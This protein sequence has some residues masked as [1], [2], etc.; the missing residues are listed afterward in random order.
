[1][2]TSAWAQFHWP[3]LGVMAVFACL[4]VYNTHS[5][6]DPSLLSDG[7]MPVYLKQLLFLAI[8][9]GAGGVILLFDYRISE[10]LAY[11]FYGLIVLALVA[12]LVVGRSAAARSVGWISGRCRFSQ[13]SSVNLP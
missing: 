3:L 7:E 12:V 13:V 1:M 6:V 4:G 8:G 10:S 5:A 2:K 11:L 9:F